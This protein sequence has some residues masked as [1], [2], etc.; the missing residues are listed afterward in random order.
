MS[1]KIRFCSR[2]DL[3]T[4]A[5]SVCF[6]VFVAGAS[7]CGDDGPTV[8][9]TQA[10]LV[11]DGNLIC[12]EGTQTRLRG[13]VGLSRDPQPLEVRTYVL[14]TELPILRR[15]VELLASLDA[16]PMLRSTLKRL[17]RNATKALADLKARPDRIS[18]IRTL[19]APALEVARELGLTAC[20]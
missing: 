17:D 15:E 9:L 20:G 4:I 13:R 1:L 2:K 8:P 16:P 10:Q 11:N 7:G 19:F 5:L 12:T 6:A 18:E 3:R 14:E